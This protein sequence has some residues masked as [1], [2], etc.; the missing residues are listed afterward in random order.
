[1]EDFSAT[2]RSA[3]E[4]D[5][6]AF[7]RLFEFA[8][9]ALQRLLRRELPVE[10]LRAEF[11][12]DLLQQ[13]YIETW[14][15]LGAIED[16]GPRAFT[17]WMA[18]IA[19]RNLLNAIRW[20]RR[21]KRGGGARPLPLIEATDEPRHDLQES[22]SFAAH[23]DEACTLLQAGL[24]SLRAS[25][26]ELIDLFHGRGLTPGQI[27][28]IVGKTPGSVNMALRRLEVRLRRRLRGGEDECSH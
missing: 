11:D 9:P 26:R 7:R 28:R 27:G 6:E 22:P 15:A 8:L 5:E 25:Q 4:G 2:L 13:T 24:D 1:M 21:L 16:R 23:R 10:F 19:R 18:T 3:R 20:E 12:L 14:L 17:G